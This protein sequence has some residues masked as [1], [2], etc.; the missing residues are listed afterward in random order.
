[1]NKL[2]TTL[3]ASA[4]ALSASAAV[5]F[6]NYV[7]V[8]ATGDVTEISTIEVTFP[9]CAE[10]EIMSGEGIRMVNANDEAV[11][12]TAEV[13]YGTNKLKFTPEATITSSGTY[14]LII[15]EYSLTGY[16]EDYTEYLDNPTEM[17][18][19][20][21]IKNQSGV[22][23][24]DNPVV[25]PAQGTVVSLET[26]SITFPD[27]PEVTVNDKSRVTMTRE[28]ENVSILSISDGNAVTIQLSE[29]MTAP[30]VYVL[31][32]PANELKGSDDTANQTDLVFKWEILSPVTYDLTLALSSP[33]KPNE[34]GEIS[35][36]KQ[37]LS[38]FFVSE[39]TG[40]DVPEGTENNV[41]L[42]EIDGDLELHGHLGKAYGSDSNKSYFAAEFNDEPRYNG[43]Y[44]IVI[45]KGAFGDEK[46]IANPEFGHS[47]DQIVLTFT[48][49]DGADREFY[50][51]EP[52][53]VTPSET[54]VDS[55]EKLREFTIT[56]DTDVTV[57]E[58]AYATLASNDVDYNQ[59]ANI[60]P[61]DD[62][63]KFTVTFT[64][65]PVEKGVYV[66]NIL[67][68]AFAG[69]DGNLS[70]NIVREYTIDGSDAIDTV[71]TE[72]GETAVYNLHGVRVDA[73]NLPAGIYIVNG[74]KVVVK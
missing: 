43:K 62:S 8:P 57:T 67:Q 17:T 30:G 42:R 18:L 28:G 3:A 49:V 2:F 72:N 69:A 21:T 16:N 12:G 31:T 58:G 60:V 13:P 6:D 66:F 33:T 9:G 68:G 24:F 63:R 7:S 29:A 56:F 11:A 65:V 10:I 45:N 44:E 34:N 55:G 5:T 35:A 1:M 70:A 37:L 74:K 51:I 52:I 40:L 59:S 73:E 36:N 61:T 27:A 32:I 48:L 14:K 64:T 25:S 19:T 39:M 71:S 38:F 20:Y 41:T 26:I 22:I 54:T 23:S 15:G 46:W 47:N 50:T 4:I 53:E